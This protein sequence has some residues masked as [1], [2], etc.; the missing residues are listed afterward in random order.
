MA[1]VCGVSFL[2][3]T[4]YPIIQNHHG[5]P[6]GISGLS[7]IG[8]WLEMALATI[9]S[10]YVDRLYVYHVAQLGANQLEARL[11]HLISVT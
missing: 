1:F 11:P 10:L 7:F 8:I 9:F 4:S 2:D 3:L 5:W 6:V